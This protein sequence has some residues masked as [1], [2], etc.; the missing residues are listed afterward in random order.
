MVRY[1]NPDSMA[2]GSHKP[3]ITAVIMQTLSKYVQ[4]PGEASGVQSNRRLNPLEFKLNE[5]PSKITIKHADSTLTLDDYLGDNPA[6]DAT[7]D[8]FA[9]DPTGGD[10]VATVDFLNIHDDVTDVIA[11][12][13]PSNQPFWFEKTD[14]VVA[15]AAD[16]K[17]VAKG[18]TSGDIVITVWDSLDN[19]SELT[20]EGITLDGN[21]PGVIN[22]FPTADDAPKDADNEDRPTID[23]VTRNPVFNINEELDSLSI[24]YHEAGGGTVIVQAYSPGSSRLETVGSLVSWPVND[25]LIDRQRYNLEVL[26]IDLAGNASVKKGGTLT[27][28]DVF[29]NPDA[30]S[31][32]VVPDVDRKEKQVAGVDYAI[33]LSVLDNELSAIEDADVR[34]V[35]YHTPS[36]V[37]A[38]VTGDQAEALEGASFSGTGVTE[39]PAFTLPAPLAAAGMVAKAAILDGDAWHAGQR[40]VKFKSTKPLT[41]VILMAA[42]GTIDPATG[43]FALRIS[44]RAAKPINIEIAEFSKFTLTAIEGEIS[45]DNVAGAFSVRVV[46]TDAFANPSLRIENSP[47]AKDYASVAFTFASSNAAVSV[48]SGQQ[49]VTSIDGSTYGAVAS[50]VGGSATISVRTVV[51]TYTTGAAQA[52]DANRR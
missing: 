36:A 34:A 43:A 45:A 24:R 9:L 10:K 22:L 21:T 30:D 41:N 50:D 35:T 1:P 31:F 40:T 46:P 14:D 16:N 7:E 6:T 26:A 27:F 39:A 2:A 37:A 11:A 49:M 29:M 32:K 38:I 13:R 51:D 48:P 23:P 5:A 33:A 20:L 42:E 19:K 44:G 28:K 52:D 47:G 3:L 25:T 18:G 12:N 17:Y 8:D 4:L 15:G